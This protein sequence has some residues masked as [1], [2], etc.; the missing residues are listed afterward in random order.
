[1]TNNRRRER[2]STWSTHPTIIFRE[3][4]VEEGASLSEEG[5][6]ETQGAEQDATDIIKF[7]SMSCTSFNH[8]CNERTS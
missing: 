2:E 5:T 3:T 6:L 7:P 4:L 1:M 8:E